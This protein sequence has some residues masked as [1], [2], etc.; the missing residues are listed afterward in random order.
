MSTFRA[1]AELGERLEKTKSRL[2]LTQY[3]ADYIRGLNP[4]EI[5]E[6]IYLILGQIFP[7]KANIKLNLSW[8]ALRDV[9]NLYGDRYRAAFS[10]A[11]DVGEGVKRLYE[12]R[13]VKPSLPPLQI[14]D[15]YKSL[16]A[17]ALLKGKGSR[18]EK[19]RI[20][21]NLFSRCSGIEAKY[22]S[23]IVIGEMRHGV[24]EGIAQEAIARAFS[25]PSELIRKAFLLR[26]D[27]GEVA[28]LAK[29][30]RL[31]DVKL[32]LFNP[33]KPML[34]QTAK[35]ISEAFEILKQRFAL[36]YK[37]DGARVQIHKDRE[38]VKIF[39]RRLTDITGSLEE[40]AQLVMDNLKI[41]KG[42]VEGEV[43]AVDKN[44]RPLPFQYLMHR[45]TRKRRPQ[46]L[47][48]VQLYLFDCLFLENE[49]LLDT[50]YEERRDILSEIRGDIPLSKLI[51]PKDI[52]EAE[53]FLKEAMDNGQE[54]VMAKS[55]EG[56][57]T[58]GVRGKLWLK[59]KPVITLDLVILAADWGYGRR[60]RWLSN[61]HLGVY[62]K[63]RFLEVGKT[64]KG[65]N[66]K[67]FE[68]ITQKLLSLKIDERGG[69]VYTKPQ[70]VVEVAF[71]EI[72]KSPHYPSGL[73][74]RFA[75]II[76]IREDKRP[77]EVTTLDQLK[78]LYEQQFLK[79]GRI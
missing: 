39:S 70:I 36:E 58:L 30:G 18:G 11:E 55:L 46:P 71:N 76:R 43:V 16:R 68:Y 52:D 22:L 74:L 51:I 66:D 61:Y 13:K 8:G 49:V 3:M 35:D 47:L 65:L 10:E 40:I 77:E 7:E 24:N 29:E 34:A 64:F 31:S 38:R 41:E 32:K 25:V 60:Y 17:I 50:P 9:L 62:D 42:V 79:K 44:N 78:N 57:Y 4:D 53:R 45:L 33:L 27:L 14:R 37:Y 20:L 75:R 73:A 23:K 1:L 59:I 15:V 21:K 6:F 28:T 48:R 26:G 5:P 2:K 63:G 72:Q 67:E 56:N 12:L 19:E 69:T 54:G